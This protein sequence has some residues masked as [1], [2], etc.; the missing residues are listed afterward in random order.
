MKKEIFVTCNIRQYESHPCPYDVEINDADPNDESRYCDC[1][2]FC[3]QE[4]RWNI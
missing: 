4:C 2:P 1:C 3:E